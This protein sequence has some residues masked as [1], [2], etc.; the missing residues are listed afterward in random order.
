[1]DRTLSL[2]GCCVA[3]LVLT[4]LRASGRDPIDAHTA[5]DGD[6]ARE[7]GSPEPDFR[8]ASAALSLLAGG[9]ALL[10]SGRRRQRG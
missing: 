7:R 9:G 2:L 5:Q 10:L 6:E 8:A 1:V 4:P 3:L